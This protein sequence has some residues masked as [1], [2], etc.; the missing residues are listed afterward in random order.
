MKLLR[1]PLVHFLVAGAALFAA[2]G[3]FA[4]GG[5][6][7]GP[8]DRTIVVGEREVAWL[9]E[10]WERQRQR[11]PTADELRGL[12]LDYLRE[13]LLAR[14][15]R[16]LELDRDDTVVRRR[17]AQ[18]MDFIL[19]ETAQRAEPAEDDLRRLYETGA[20][21][22]AAPA[23]TSFVHVFF[24]SEGREELATAEARTALDALE[25]DPERAFADL[26]DPT[27]LPAEIEG[28]DERDIAGQFG[29]EFAA[30]VRELA[31]GG[32]HGPIRSAFGIHLVRV[33]ARTAPRPR[34][35]EQVRDELV[36]SWHREGEER[37][38]AAYFADLVREYDVEVADDLRPLV[39]PALAELRSVTP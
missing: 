31:P 30:A 35:F 29:V 12:V 37:A 27:L 9:A 6:E 39:D 17:L 21:R 32:W 25:R 22:F 3:W 7:P 15:A 2:Y 1:E 10:T 11:P 28:A 4:G 23:T 24:R 13:E 38:R 20:G 8:V 36:A 14:E 18:K 19:G 34:A 26:G 33:T 5:R 16:K